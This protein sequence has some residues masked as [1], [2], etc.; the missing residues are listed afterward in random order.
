MSNM[1]AELGAQVGLIAPDQVTAEYVAAAGGQLADDWLDY[2]I[3]TADRPEDHNHLHRPYS[4]CVM[5]GVALIRAN[6]DWMS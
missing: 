5:C 1:A 2:R 3:E 6:P 4:N